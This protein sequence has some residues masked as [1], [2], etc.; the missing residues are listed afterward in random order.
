MEKKKTSK[1]VWAVIAATLVVAVVAL[2]IAL[3]A[4]NKAILVNGTKGLSAYELAV[5]DGYEGTLEQWLASLVGETGKDGKSAYDLAVENGYEGDVTTWLKSLVGSNGTNGTNGKSAYELAVDNGYMGSLD[6]LIGKDGLDGKDGK[7]GKDGLSAYEL[8]VA[9][10]YKGS[11]TEWLASLVGA[12]GADGKSAYDLA[13]ENGYD[14]TL[15]DW[16]AALVGATGKDGASAYELAVT[17]G[18]KGTEEEWIN[19]LA[20]KD[21]KSAYEIAVEHGYTG[22][23]EEWLASLKG[24]DGK[25]GANGTDGVSV[26][27]VRVNDDKHLIVTLSDGTEIDAGYVGVTDTPSST[28][29]TVI[30][31]DYDGT[32]LKTESV[33]QGKSATAPANPSRDGY[34]FTGWDKAFSNI[35]SDIVV[36]AQ[37]E[38]ITGAY[39]KCD[40]YSVD[41]GSTISIPVKLVNSTDPIKS[42]GISISN[43]S[44]NFNITKGSWSS[45]FDYEIANFNKTRLQGVATL[46]EQSVVSGDIFNLTLNVP[47]TAESGTYTLT[48]SLKTTYFDSNEDEKEIPCTPVTISITVK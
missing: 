43:D 21:G 5:Q 30:F 8:A 24:A 38:K 7:D 23:E 22:T 48:I 20:G 34:V 26:K 9:N 15:Q 13:V 12:Q 27:S 47:N 42:L 44:Q 17:H 29:Y 36:T 19:S 28:T 25:D 35:T 1:A 18:Y 45:D 10:G 46:S 33:A 41:K 16:L 2:I 40:D 3:V 6:S 39:L 11:L 31:K 4:N 14:G 32:V 37:Y